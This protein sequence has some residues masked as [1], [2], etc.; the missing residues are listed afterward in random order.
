MT[1]IGAAAAL[2]ASLLAPAGRMPQPGA[3]RPVGPG[4]LPNQVLWS[5]SASE[6]GSRPRLGPIA[7]FGGAA[8]VLDDGAVVGLD[9][10]KGLVLWRFASGLDA[11]QLA[12]LGVLTL[13]AGT[14]FGGDECV[15]ELRAFQGTDGTRLWATP[16]PA[17]AHSLQSLGDVVIAVLEGGQVAA[18][19]LGDGRLRWTA[20]VGPGPAVAAGDGVYVGTAL[21]LEKR[22]RDDGSLLW[23]R[24]LAAAVEVAPT[25]LGD[26]VVVATADGHVHGLDAADGRSA[27]SHDLGGAATAALSTFEGT[28]L[29]AT[30]ADQLIRLKSN[31]K[32]QWRAAIE[33]R[34]RLPP[35]TWQGQLLVATERSGRVAAFEP[36][37]GHASGV[38]GLDAGQE[39]FTGPVAG[40][41]DQLVALTNRGRVLALGPG[42]PAPALPLLA[43][44]ALPAIKRDR[45]R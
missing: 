13:V 3:P 22:S 31:G 1:H 29:V 44:P 20:S 18:L 36:R 25:L 37:R 12:T 32:P 26:R 35:T 28:A 24:Q 9:P 23:Q 34:L 8:V 14:P 27:W 11:L 19:E 39:W 2:I 10:E 45:G 43:M 21:G 30:Y 41:L 15:P 38:S 16:L 40:F 33:G 6:L 7:H 17:V 4:V 42:A 5:A